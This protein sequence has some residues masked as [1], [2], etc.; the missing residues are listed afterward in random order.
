ML[1][2]TFR[3]GPTSGSTGSGSRRGTSGSTRDQFRLRAAYSLDA[4]L[5]AAAFVQYSRAGESVA[6]NLRVRYRFSEGRDLWI[7]YNDLLDADRVPLAGLPRGPLSLN[8]T[9][10]MKYTHTFTR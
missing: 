3:P 4:R 9:L 5:S 1:R 10:A 2:P 6:A 8:R 7:V